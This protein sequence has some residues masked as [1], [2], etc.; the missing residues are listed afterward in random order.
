MKAKI[1]GS[2]IDYIEHVL[3]INT[4]VLLQMVK[5]EKKG[6]IP[7]TNY[8]LEDISETDFGISVLITEKGRVVF[9]G[10]IFLWEE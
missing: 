4:D 9:R 6:K 3:G 5:K 10:H 8:K 2:N 1:C 7:N